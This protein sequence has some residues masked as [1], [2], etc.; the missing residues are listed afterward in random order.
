MQSKPDTSDNKS[1]TRKGPQLAAP[2]ARALSVGLACTMAM[3][4]LI[5]L[6]LRMVS[7][8]PRSAYADPA[9]SQSPEPTPAT[10]PAPATHAT[11]GGAILPA[12]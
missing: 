1:P 6:K 8:V 3:G 4:L 2:V 7:D 12:P 5:W 9:R 10:E 11:G